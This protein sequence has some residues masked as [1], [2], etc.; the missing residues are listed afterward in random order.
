MIE[1]TREINNKIQAKRQELVENGIKL[2]GKFNKIANQVL[3]D[4]DLSDYEVSYVGSMWRVNI[5]EKGTAERQR[6]EQLEQWE[7]I[8][9]SKNF[10]KRV[11]SGQVEK[12][13]EKWIDKH[14]G[15]RYYVE[16]SRS[17]VK[18]ESFYICRSD[19]GEKIIK[20][21]LHNTVFQEFQYNTPFVDLND[22]SST[23]TLKEKLK[24][25][26]G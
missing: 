26:L 22:F 1:L 11:K 4:Y 18:S 9:K 23:I 7:A 3:A 5:N 8:R 21:S 25:M 24:E 20:L 19:N 10:I 17:L 16:H 13:I 2:R 15:D 12:S 14:Y 6:K